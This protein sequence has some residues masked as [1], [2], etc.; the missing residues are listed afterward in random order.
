MAVS[1]TS[2]R[3]DILTA[4][5]PKG[6]AACLFRSHELPEPAFFATREVLALS[7]RPS[8][9]GS[10][11]DRVLPTGLPEPLSSLVRGELV[12]LVGRSSSGR[13]AIALS[14]IASATE[15][16]ECAALV[17]LGDNFDPQLGEAAGVDL[18]RLFWLRPRSLE[19]ALVCAEL[20]L[21]AGFA[22]VVLELGLARPSRRNA[23]E[24]A[25][26][27]LSIR[28]RS[29]RGALLVLTPSPVSGT[30]AAAVLSA[31]RAGAVWEKGLLVG[32]SSRLTLDKRRGGR[33]GAEGI[34]FLR[35][36]ETVAKSPDLASHIS[37]LE[38]RNIG[39]SYLP[40]TNPSSARHANELLALKRA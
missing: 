15:M 35:L 14:A 21:G 33:P 12:E 11:D 18:A 17:D 6:V 24:A 29:H 23:P 5:L 37:L 2:S 8:I 36:R 28:A 25:W 20:V 27:R 39:K 9:P 31:S 16:G 3:L 4:S 13:F 30:A 22:L 7:R 38:A 26:R 10:R 40:R 34:L 1:A 19:A 32:L